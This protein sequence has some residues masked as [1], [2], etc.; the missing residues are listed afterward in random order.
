M[1]TTQEVEQYAR[2]TFK[3]YGLHDYT[4]YWNPHVKRTLGF[5]NPWEKKVELNKKVL[6][7][8]SL[9]K[10]VLLHEIMHVL[11]FNERGTFK[12]NGRNDFH[13]KSFKAMCKKHGVSP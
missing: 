12:R 13:G 3:Q 7:S 8:F 1:L 10:Y 11:D 5:A 4:L 9:F 6:K 2:L